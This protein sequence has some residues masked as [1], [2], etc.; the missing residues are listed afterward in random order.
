MFL[1]A[2]ASLLPTM[3]LAWHVLLGSLGVRAG[4]ETY[5]WGAH[6]AWSLL[7]AWLYYFNA[8]RFVRWS[9]ALHPQESKAGEPWIARGPQTFSVG[10]G[11]A[12]ALIVLADPADLARELERIRSGETATRTLLE[13]ILLSA[14]A[15]LSALI[16]GMTGYSDAQQRLAVRRFSFRTLGWILSPM[17]VRPLACDKARPHLQ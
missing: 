9:L 4:Y 10:A 7:G 5:V 2:V 14:V 8:R 6:F 12:Q 15:P 13:G 16:A 17:L 3:I 11:Y 1:L